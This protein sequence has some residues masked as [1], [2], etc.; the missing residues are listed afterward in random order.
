[1][2]KIQKKPKPDRRRKTAKPRLC[3]AL[4]PLDTKSIRSGL[5][6]KLRRAKRGF[7]KTEAE[8]KHHIENEIHCFDLWRRTHFGAELNHL[9]MRT[10][11][12]DGKQYLHQLIEDC[13]ETANLSQRKAY[14]FIIENSSDDWQEQ[15]VFAADWF[16][17]LEEEE[18]LK[19]KKSDSCD[20][21][22]ED[23]EDDYHVFEY[24]DEFL[25]EMLENEFDD[26]HFS[27]TCRKPDAR[28]QEI[29]RGLC[30]RLHP[31][32][33]VEFDD[34]LR[35]L[36]HEVQSAYSDRDLNR[37]E[38][39]Q[40]RVDAGSELESIGHPTCAEIITRTAEFKEGTSAIR[41]SIR[42][43]K[44]DISW[45]FDPEDKKKVAEASDY[46]RQGFA[47]EHSILDDLEERVAGTLA[48]LAKPVG[49]RKKKR[50]KTGSKQTMTQGEFDF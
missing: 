31:D 29:Y 2:Q 50:S 7:E 5:I 42:R 3:R 46:M 13:A 12:L 44:L 40:A 20:E 16:D 27:D 8:F 18:E 34:D 15:L 35:E 36:W 23:D 41:E 26:N 32:T 43:A 4:V 24:I 14:A 6:K 33:G 30:K 21:D 9:L 19:W 38:I 47:F 1:M 39:L 28:I 11:E 49:G 17:R 10:R 48:S 37:L 25:R 45:G 22:D